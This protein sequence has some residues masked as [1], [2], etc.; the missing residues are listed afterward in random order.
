MCDESILNDPKVRRLIAKWKRRRAMAAQPQGNEAELRRLIIE[1]ITTQ[2]GCVRGFSGKQARYRAFYKAQEDLREAVTGE[3]DLPRA[4]SVL[5]TGEKE[6]IGGVSTFGLPKKK[7]PTVSPA[8][9][10]T[11]RKRLGGNAKRT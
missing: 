1:W 3:R 8:L 2:F 9:R 6:I 5:V 10:H 11:R 7:T 4:G